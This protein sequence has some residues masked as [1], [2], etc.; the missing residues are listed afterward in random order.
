MVLFQQAAADPQK[1][2]FTFDT[3]QVIYL[4]LKIKKKL[5]DSAASLLFQN[6]FPLT[7]LLQS[8]RSLYYQI[9][10]M[11]LFKEAPTVM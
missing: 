3:L 10:H 5:F 11:P 2:S 8:G 6:I 9:S 7:V 1:R 4:T